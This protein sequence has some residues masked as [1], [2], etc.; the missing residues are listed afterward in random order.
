MTSRSTFHQ[1]FRVISGNLATT[2]AF[3]L[4]V[5]PKVKCLILE[6]ILHIICNKAI[7]LGQDVE[8]WWQ[9][10]AMRVN[11]RRAAQYAKNNENWW[12]SVIIAQLARILM[13]SQVK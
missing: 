12:Q 6:K 13:T 8:Y 11:V 2:L 3:W 1:R 10:I 5:T 7:S 9:N 4:V